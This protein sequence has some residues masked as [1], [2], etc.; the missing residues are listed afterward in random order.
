MAKTTNAIPTAKFKYFPTWKLKEIID[1]G[2][3]TSVGTDYGFAM[4]EVINVY[5]K[6]LAKMDTKLLMQDLKALDEMPTIE[7]SLLGINLDNDFSLSDTPPPIPE[8]IALP[9]VIIDG[10]N[11]LLGISEP[12][13]NFYPYCEDIF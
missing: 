7:E 4:D 11:L 9:P 3:M 5:N 6:R 1:N 13:T 10:S 8:E 2:G 12:T